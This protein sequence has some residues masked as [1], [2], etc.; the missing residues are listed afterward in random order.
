MHTQGCRVGVVGGGDGRCLSNV[1]LFSQGLRHSVVWCGE[2]ALGLC[3]GSPASTTTVSLK[4]QP[5]RNNAI[6]RRGKRVPVPVAVDAP[7]ARLL[8]LQLG[9]GQR[10]SCPLA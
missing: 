7:G 10:A 3:L 6:K 5:S 4:P 2:V 9:A 1:A 8:I